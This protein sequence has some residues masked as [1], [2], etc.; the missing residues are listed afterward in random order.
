M[1]I[2][3]KIENG[4]AVAASDASLKNGQIAGRWCLTDINQEIELVHEA[5]YEN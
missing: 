5:C 3:Q 2:A 1:L 4:T